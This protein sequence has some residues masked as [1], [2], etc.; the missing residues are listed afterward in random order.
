MK[1]VISFFF[2]F[3]VFNTVHLQ[4][5]QNLDLSDISTVGAP[6][7]YFDALATFPT[8]IDPWKVSNGTPDISTLNPN[9]VPFQN[10]I[11]FAGINRRCGSG[12]FL[13]GEGFYYEGHTFKKDKPYEMTF[14][15]RNITDEVLA[16]NITLF[17]GLT[18]DNR[19]DGCGSNFRS[20]AHPSFDN[21]Q[22]VYSVNRLNTNEQ[23]QEVTICF[24]PEQDFTQIWF[25]AFDNNTDETPRPDASI[26]EIG[27]I[28]F[29]CC[30]ENLIYRGTERAEI[31][32]DLD[33][34]RHVR[35]PELAHASDMVILD[36][37]ESEILIKSDQTVN[38]KAG[39]SIQIYPNRFPFTTEVGAVVNLEIA[40]CDCGLESGD[41]CSSIVP[42]LEDASSFQHLYFPNAFSPNDDGVNDYWGP[43]WGSQY[44]IP[45]NATGATLRIFSRWGDLLYEQKYGTHADPCDYI[46]EDNEIFWDGCAGGLG[47][48]PGIIYVYTLELSNCYNSRVRS[49]DFSSLN[50]ANCN[51]PLTDNQSGLKS[52]NSNKVDDSNLTKN[53]QNSDSE[54]VI[55]P[56]LTTTGTNIFYNIRVIENNRNQ[57]GNLFVVNSLGKIVFNQEIDTNASN[58]IEGSI[59]SEKFEAGFYYVILQPHTGPRITRKLIVQ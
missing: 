39:N 21:T 6:G 26:A 18:E 33:E 44:S 43:A 12:L 37:F 54:F 2:V 32:G 40:P 52:P 58:S 11:Q 30:E 59:I 10:S 7:L 15:I 19:Q 28:S 29:T 51:S 20:Y 36:P 53:I 16:I 22:N 56:S 42:S 31:I 23:Y 14:F 27:G 34:T 41:K 49:G 5:F 1:L 13:G 8:G 25:G 50:Y 57:Y 3:S 38:L 48:G 17:N 24:E 55:F 9:N 4:E 45:Y 47:V 46:I 35:L